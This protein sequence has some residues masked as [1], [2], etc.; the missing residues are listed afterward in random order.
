MEVAAL[1]SGMARRLCIVARYE[2]SLYG[3]LMVALPDPVEVILDRRGNPPEARLGPDGSPQ[4]ER[5]RPR[6]VEAALRS[7]GY[8]ILG[9]DGM[10]EPKAEAVTPVRPR[11]RMLRAAEKRPAV[12]LGRLAA[13]A[14]TTVGAGTAALAAGLFLLITVPAALPRV[15]ARV[16][17][18]VDAGARVAGLAR[19]PDI[20][21]VTERA[22]ALSLAPPSATPD[23][24]RTAP[25]PASAPPVAVVWPAGVAPAARTPAPPPSAPARR[26]PPEPAA[27]SAP[28]SSAPTRPAPSRR[29][30]PDRETRTAERPRET[31]R[32]G[33]EASPASPAVHRTWTAPR[34]PGLPLVEMAS[35]ETGPARTRNVTYT[36]QLHDSAGRPLL[37]ADV[38]LHAVMPDGVAVQARLTP[39][40]APGTYRGVVAGRWPAD[41]LRVRALVDGRRFEIP[42]EP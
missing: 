31:P 1:E 34:I 8:V 21:T 15:V 33:P 26:E 40:S 38:S 16:A 39:T 29:E 19:P 9:P 2:P 27:A 14:L 37:A 18:W 4:P 24:P 25:E 17:S 11:V 6:G 36:A 3:Y 28:S 13:V 7:E 12:H 23:P 32:A 41:N 20:V 35:E 30:P 22:P 5:R 42:L 10:P